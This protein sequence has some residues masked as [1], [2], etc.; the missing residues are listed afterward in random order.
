M[1]SRSLKS[2]RI[3]RRT[4]RPII[5]PDLTA[6]HAHRP[7]DWGQTDGVYTFLRTIAAAAVIFI[8]GQGSLMSADGELQEP[9]RLAEINQPRSMQTSP[10]MRTGLH[11][12]NVRTDASHKIR[13]ERESGG[14]PASPGKSDDEKRRVMSRPTRHSIRIVGMDSAAKRDN[15][16]SRRPSRRRATESSASN[17]SKWIH[18]DQVIPAQATQEPDIDALFAPGGTLDDFQS[19][20]STGTPTPQDEAEPIPNPA[21]DSDVPVDDEPT[22]VDDPAP[23]SSEQPM[24]PPRIP[25]SEQIPELRPDAENGEVPF[26]PESCDEKQALC[27][28]LLDELKR[29]GLRDINLD[30]SLA[31]TEGIDFPCF[32]ADISEPYEDRQFAQLTYQWTAS[33]ICHKPLY[34]E[35]PALERHGHTVP[36]V[37]PVISAAH[38]F[39][40]L[41]ALPYCVGMNPPWECKYTLGHYR[42]GSCAPYMVPPVPLSWRGA[43]VQGAVTTGV[44]FTVP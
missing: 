8:G 44:V 3:T 43:A 20:E 22:N 19:P 13:R 36:L 28:E 31:G 32:C 14:L 26:D 16:T 4:I 15:S 30:I 5:R 24:I 21:L 37:H 12:R 27:R 1:T 39:G 6:G 17:T 2:H 11:I 34:F 35:E 9:V 10:S 18:D 42:M 23:S 38:F 29:K 40:T 25:Y 7:A 33:S 41:P